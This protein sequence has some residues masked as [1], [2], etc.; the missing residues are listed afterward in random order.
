MWLWFVE[1][2][3]EMDEIWHKPIYIIGYVVA[4][5]YPNNV[6]PNY[7]SSSTH[8]NGVILKTFVFQDI[9]SS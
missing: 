4:L 2:L 6:L 9:N 1:K 7:N 8:N 3:T 5:F